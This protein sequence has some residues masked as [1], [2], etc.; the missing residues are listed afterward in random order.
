MY[1]ISK[2]AMRFARPNV[3]L[4]GNPVK[5]GSEGDAAQQ[6]NK[7]VDFTKAY[8]EIHPS[9]N[10]QEVPD[11]VEDEIQFQRRLED[12]SVV[13]VLPATKKKSA[14]EPG[15]IELSSMTKAELVEHAANVHDLDLDVSK[16]KAELIDHINEAAKG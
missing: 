7:Q 3:Q 5:A 8:V 12:G 11:W 6:V 16:T 15:E 2:I 1:V 9:P 4:L 13:K 10:V 14:P